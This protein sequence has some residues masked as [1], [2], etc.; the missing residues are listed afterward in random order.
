F[1]LSNERKETEYKAVLESVLEDI[2]NLIA[3]SNGLL[4]LAQVGSGIST[5]G[6]KKIRLDEL[7]FQ[8]ISELSKKYPHQQMNLKVNDEQDDERMFIFQGNEQ[9]LRTAFINPPDNACTF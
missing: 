5:P 1:S 8:C 9:L 3:L 6:L 2:N 4:D 7:L